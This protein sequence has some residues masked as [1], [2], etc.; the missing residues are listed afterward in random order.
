MRSTTPAPTTSQHRPTTPAPP[1]TTSQNRPTTPASTQTPTPSQQAQQQMTRLLGLDEFEAKKK[2][3]QQLLN[4]LTADKMEK[5]FDV[6]NLSAQQAECI[7]QL[8]S[9]Y[10]ELNNA[11]ALAV[12]AVAA[13]AV[14]MQDNL[15]KPSTPVPPTTYTNLRTNHTPNHKTMLPQLDN[16]SDNTSTTDYLP[17]VYIFIFH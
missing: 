14:N 10:A 8:Q 5:R 4:Q 2:A 16:V 6:N 13:A 17:E 15:S 11:A 7:I 3:A 12:A 9:L 1:T